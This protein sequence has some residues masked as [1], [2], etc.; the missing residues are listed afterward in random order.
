VFFTRT[1]SENKTAESIFNSGS[2]DD[3][4]KKDNNE[5][6]NKKNSLRIAFG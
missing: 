5:K 6:S 4:E 1:F 2:D 3:N